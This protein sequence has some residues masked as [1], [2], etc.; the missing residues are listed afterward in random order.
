M[1]SKKQADEFSRE[2]KEVSI[3]VT[4]LMKY[5]DKYT[6]HLNSSTKDKLITFNARGTRY[7]ILL[8]QLDSVAD[9]RFEKIKKCVDLSQSDANK[10]HEL[11]QKE[12][13]ADFHNEYFD[14]F[15]LNKDPFTFSIILD[16]YLAIKKEEK[17]H[18]NSKSV[19]SAS[20]IAELEFWNIKEFRT[21]LLP[22]CL[23]ELDKKNESVEED[24]N[25]EKEIIDKYVIGKPEDFGKWC[26]PE[27]RRIVWHILD[28]PK[29]SFLAMV[30]YIDSFNF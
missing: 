18:L 8:D 29:S 26:F 4:Q 13:L 16:F 25:A 5:I 17:V 23:N 10:A 3:D 1:T 30:Y 20:L 28:K 12:K 14:E 6:E 2:L 19:C 24:V 9:S 11:F 15:Y 27:F 7:E 22:C 21:F